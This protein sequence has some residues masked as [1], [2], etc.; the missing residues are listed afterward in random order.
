[1]EWIVFDYAG[2]VCLPP[3]EHAGRLLADT[4]AVD[5][6]DFWPVY[7]HHRRAYDLG[8]LTAKDYWTAVCNSLGK[9]VEDD[10]I[11]VFVELDVRAWMHLNENTLAVL[12]GLSAPLALLSNAPVELARRIDSRPWAARFEHRLYS[13]DLGLAK[14]D[15]QIFKVTCERLDARPEDLLFVDDRLENVEAARALGIRSVLFTDGSDLDL[16]RGR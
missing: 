4:M 15:P 2:V 11:E 9:P 14:P 10:L 13:A 7:W 16:G 8:V 3:P 6:A 12:E 5:P 1:M